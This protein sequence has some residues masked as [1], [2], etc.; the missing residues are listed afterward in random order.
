MPSSSPNQR[1]SFGPP[2]PDFP[3]L[4]HIVVA[5]YLGWTCAPAIV[6]SMV[7]NC[8]TISTVV[9][10]DAVYADELLSIKLLLGPHGSD[11]V[12]RIARVFMAITESMDLHQKNIE[13]DFGL[14]ERF[15]HL[16]SA[17]RVFK[18]F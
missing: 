6:L 8:L 13:S 4:T 9:F 12:N 7:G 14:P 11:R 2:H 1:Y 17:L 15:D 18:R 5:S 16:Q 3:P 10:T